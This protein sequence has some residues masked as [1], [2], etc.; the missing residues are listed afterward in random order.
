[1]SRAGSP[2][3]PLPARPLAGNYPLTVQN[4][5]AKIVSTKGKGLWM[6]NLGVNP[7]AM[8]S[9]GGGPARQGDIDRVV[10]AIE[11][12]IQAVERQTEIVERLV[13]A[14]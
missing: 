14:S 10:E 3:F 7:Q 6:S 13:Q 1:M 2:L 12:L 8:A 4:K 9:A 11:R 5:R